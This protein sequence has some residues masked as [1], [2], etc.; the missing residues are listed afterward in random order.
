MK[1]I[2]AKKYVKAL[3]SNLK[4]SEF[5]EVN[6]GLKQL[7]YA[8]LLPKLGLILNLPNLTQKDKAEFL[9]S[10]SQSKNKKLLNL[11]KILGD[12]KKFDII[13]QI[14]EEFAYQKALKDNTFRGEILGNFDISE[15]KK[16]ELEEK[17]SKK[18]G[19]KIQFDIVKNDYDGIKIELDDLGVEVN[20]SM[21]NLKAKM[22][23]YI[24]KSIQ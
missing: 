10:L 5:D 22:S 20:F 17:F 15:S 1:E 18:F 12:N 21:S 14:Y 24:M 3:A 13:P 2:V 8:F 19:S 9:F 16:K 7:A 23:E 11:L 4:D 6:A